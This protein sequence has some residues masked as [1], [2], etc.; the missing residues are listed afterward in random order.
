LRDYLT[1]LCLTLFGAKAEWEAVAFIRDDTCIAARTKDG[2]IL[3]WTFYSDVRSLEQLAREHLP[4][5]RDRNGSQK[6]LE[7]R[8]LT[9]RR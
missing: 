7:V 2:R 6:P 9:L 1:P 5:V 3:A 8:G 4:M